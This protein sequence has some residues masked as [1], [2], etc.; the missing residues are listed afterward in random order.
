MLSLP[1]ILIYKPL[2]A[3]VFLTSL[4]SALPLYKTNNESVC[5]TTVPFSVAISGLKITGHLCG[6]NELKV[7]HQISFGLKSGEVQQSIFFKQLAGNTVKPTSG[8]ENNHY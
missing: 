6:N 3:A 5:H 1:R 8:L 7:P 4:I 2:F